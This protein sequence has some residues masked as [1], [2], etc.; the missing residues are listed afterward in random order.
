MTE[1]IKREGRFRYLGSALAVTLAVLLALLAFVYLDKKGVI[2]LPPTIGRNIRSLLL[3]AGTLFGISLILRLTLKR[4]QKLFDEPEEKIFYS[5]IFGW[6]LY[7]IGFLVF[8]HHF[9]VSLGNI[10]LFLGLIAT[11][12]AFAIREVL[13]SFFAW[14]ILL[15]KKPFRIGD[16]IRIGEDEGK[17]IHIGTFY[18]LLDKTTQLPEDY[19]RVPNRLFLEKSI[20]NLGKNTFHEE[21]TFQCTAFPNDKERL[22]KGLKAAIEGLLEN[23]ENLFIYFDLRNEKLVLVVEYLI[24]FEQRQPVRSAVIEAVH[25]YFGPWLFVPK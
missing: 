11:G 8:L 13:L 3:V 20:L 24:G 9:G 17:V 19:T 16:N 23:R 5:K 21:I 12:L 4:F 22:T 2:T 10:T 6:S 1:K 7:A 14:L 25:K 15:R 18:V